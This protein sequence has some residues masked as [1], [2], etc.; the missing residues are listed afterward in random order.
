VRSSEDIEAAPCTVCRNA[1]T[2]I[3]FFFAGVEIVG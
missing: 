3:A 1:A 2:E